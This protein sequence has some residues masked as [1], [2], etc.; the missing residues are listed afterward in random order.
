MKHQDSSNVT[1]LLHQWHDKGDDQALDELVS[2]VYNELHSLA[3]SQLKRD[4]KAT[5]QCTELVSEAY[6]KL[7]G[8]Q[9]IDY[10]NRT[11]FYSLAAKTMRRVLIERFRTKQAL[12]RGSGV[13]L[14]TYQ[15][16]LNS[17]SSQQLDLQQ[18]DASLNEL[19][20]LDP[21]QAEIVTLKFFGG[22]QNAEISQLMDISESTVKR[23]WTMAR[24]WL[25]KEI[26]K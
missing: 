14:L 15:D 24:M 19:E 23:E 9:N 17:N 6:I 26:N 21:R 10:Q 13:T 12:K 18:L 5:I 22:L 2:L 11:H 16:E 3:A 8:A 20:S 7:V 25:F 4:R 1:L